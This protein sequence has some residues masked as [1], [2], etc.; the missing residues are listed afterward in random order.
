MLII[1]VVWHSGF[2]PT[3]RFILFFADKVATIL[4]NI[5]PAEYF[6]GGR[7]GQLLTS[8]VR[9]AFAHAARAKDPI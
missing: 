5:F 1:G 9:S 6:L 4:M 3:A 2:A 7:F 8:H